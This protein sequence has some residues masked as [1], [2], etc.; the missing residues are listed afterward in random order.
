[1]GKKSEKDDVKRE[2]SIK[3]KQVFPRSSSLCHCFAAAMSRKTAKENHH[4]CAQCFAGPEKVEE[5]QQH[6]LS[7]PSI[8]TARESDR[9]GV[10]ALSVAF[11]ISLSI[12]HGD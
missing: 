5:I 2:R 1:M 9:L 6:M 10:G 3:R 4:N 7:A 8:V 11:P 12:G